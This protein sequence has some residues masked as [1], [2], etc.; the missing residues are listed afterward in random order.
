MH[1]LG[2][3]VGLLVLYFTVPL[4]RRDVTDV[5]L[6]LIACAAFALFAVAVIRMLARGAGLFRLLTLLITVVIAVSPRGELVI[7]GYQA[8]EVKVYALPE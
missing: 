2:V 7:L 3:A 8:G 6:V 5:W 1:T 4:T